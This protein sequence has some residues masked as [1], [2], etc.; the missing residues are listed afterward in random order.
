MRSGVTISGVIAGAGV[1]E[2]ELEEA[3]PQAATAS[4][5]AIT[6]TKRNTRIGPISVIE[7]ECW[8]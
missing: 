4:S 7:N 2:A 1:D 8:D 3:E 6:E 5:G